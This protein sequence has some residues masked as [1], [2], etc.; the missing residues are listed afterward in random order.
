MV[1]LGRKLTIQGSAFAKI[2][3]KNIPKNPGKN[4][5]L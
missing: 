4:R 3:T 2:K 5:N 1:K